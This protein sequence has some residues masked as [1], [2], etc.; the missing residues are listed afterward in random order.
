[1]EAALT[2]AARP[3]QNTNQR[4]A[5]N[6][7]AVFDHETETLEVTRYPKL[8]LGCFDQPIE[9]WVN[10]DITPHIWIS[11]VPFAAKF[12][13]SLGKISS[14]RLEQH[15]AGIFHRISISTWARSSPM[16]LTLLPQS[17]P[18]T[19]WNISI[20]LLHSIASGSAYGFCA[21]TEFYV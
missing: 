20:R 10:T 13:H 2:V 1:M 17:L 18:V 4:I 6:A 14:R 7:N 5:M 21:P 12:L 9:G 8:H 19:S 15:R 3:T 11:R 16:L